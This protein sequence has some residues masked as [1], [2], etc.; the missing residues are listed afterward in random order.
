MI[1]E[2]CREL[3]LTLHESTCR[4]QDRR[5]WRATIDER[6]TRAMAII[7]REGKRENEREKEIEIST[8]HKTGTIKSKHFLLVVEAA[9]VV[10]NLEEAVGRT[11][12]LTAVKLIKTGDIAE[13]PDKVKEGQHI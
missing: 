7:E 5:V 12:N 3:H 10:T 2:D 13:L 9:F 8:C 4:T 11:L 1:S 6:L